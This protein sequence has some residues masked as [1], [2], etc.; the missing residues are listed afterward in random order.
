M[1][2]YKNDIITVRVSSILKDK[3]LIANGFMW[4]SDSITQYMQ[5]IV[6]EFEAQYWIIPVKPDKAER[7]DIVTKMLWV[8]ITRHEFDAFESLYPKTRTDTAIYGD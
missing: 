1:Q 5:K 7:Y 6:R 3:F 4:L 2:L 8:K